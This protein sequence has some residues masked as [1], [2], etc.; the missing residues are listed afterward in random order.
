[1]TAHSSTKKHHLTI[2]GRGLAQ[3]LLEQFKLE[4]Q[5]LSLHHKIIPGLAV[6]LV[7]DDP[8]S[9][10]YV[11]TKTQRVRQMGIKSQDFYLPNQAKMPDLQQLVQKLNNDHAIHAILIQLPLPDHLSSRQIIDLINPAKDVDGLH[12]QNVAFLANGQPKIIPCTPAGC[13]YLL[14]QVFPAG[15]SGKN[16][17]VI[18]RSHLVGRPMAWLLMQQ[19]ATVTIAHRYTKDL[20]LHCQRA[21][22]IIAA[23]GS[24]GL[25]KGGWVRPGAVVID[26][27]I[28]RLPN[29]NAAR[30]YDLLGD[31]AFDEVQGKAAAITPVPGGVGPMT[32][33]FLIHNTI[34]LCYQSLEKP[35]PNIL[36]I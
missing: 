6:V 21:D 25:V 9:Q 14:Q 18:G 32:V 16:V 30:G 27:G 3:G 13:L 24:A 33:A 11:A 35:Y 5:E 34:K 28:N 1:M 20:A 31:V 26:V 22:I 36:K 7:G 29:P 19:N 17:V 8:A 15:I 12:S 10:L 2:D 23:A 4:V